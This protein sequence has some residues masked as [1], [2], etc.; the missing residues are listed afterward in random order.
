MAVGLS[1]AARYFRAHP[2]PEIADRHARSGR[3][4]VEP[5]ILSGR[6]IL[7]VEDEALISL[8]ITRRL[9]EAGA[10]VLAASHLEKA[11]VLAEKQDLA[12]GVL[13]F[14][15]GKTDSSAVCWKLLRTQHTLHLSQRAHV[16]RVSAMASGARC[17]EAEQSGPHWRR[18]RAVL[19]GNEIKLAG[20]VKWRSA[21]S[22]K[23]NERCD[24]GHTALHVMGQRGGKLSGKGRSRGEARPWVLNQ[25]NRRSLVPS[26]R[27]KFQTSHRD[28]R[29]A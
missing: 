26:K 3:S 27:Q 29:F 5:T 20:R 4:V 14:D 8:D 23:K 6:C 15:L 24:G 28:L 9:Q 16:Q 1:S 18:R 11:L 21:P 13:D 17:S 12:A 10:N 7:V 19:L 22:A 2:S 25:R